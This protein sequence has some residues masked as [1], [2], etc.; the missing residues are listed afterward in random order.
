MEMPKEKKKCFSCSL[1]H[2]GLSVFTTRILN[3][4]P[5]FKSISSE[6]T[7]GTNKVCHNV[8]GNGNAK[9]KE[10]MFFV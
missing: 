3:Q 2:P 4:Q 9:R 8:V 6:F 5:N 7:H 10:K 1:Q